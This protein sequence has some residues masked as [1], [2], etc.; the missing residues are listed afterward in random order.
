MS[1]TLNNCFIYIYLWWKISKILIRHTNNFC[2]SF[3]QLYLWLA[4]C[5]LVILEKLQCKLERFRRPSVFF[6]KRSLQSFGEITLFVLESTV[7]HLQRC[8]VDITGIFLT[9]NIM[10]QKFI[11][12]GC[13]PTAAVATT[14]GSLSERGVCLEGICLEKGS[15]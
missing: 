5:N 10:K 4:K 12:V 7:D 14:W 13:V 8:S 1:D 15:A 9:N 11:T 3:A 6:L 2:A